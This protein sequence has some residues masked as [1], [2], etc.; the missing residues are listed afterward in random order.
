M[1]E[2]FGEICCVTNTQALEFNFH[3]YKGLLFFLLSA[4]K[5]ITVFRYTAVAARGLLGATAGSAI[6]ERQ[7]YCLERN[8][9]KGYGSDWTLDFVQDFIL[10]R[11]INPAAN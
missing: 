2:D 1:T 6:L 9:Y 5:G 4:L 8:V 7:Q 3:S 10:I 11:N